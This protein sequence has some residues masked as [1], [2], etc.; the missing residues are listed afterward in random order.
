MPV[1][2]IKTID[3]NQKKIN[4]NND[5]VVNN[6]NAHNDAV[7]GLSLYNDNYLFSV[8]HDT[9]I[10]MWDTRKMNDAVISTVSSQKKWDE[11]MLDCY[12]IE[13]S[14]ILAVACA[15]CSVKLYKLS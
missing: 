2:T 10:K 8:S 1:N 15:D 4:N 11:A 5:F 6:L 13:S 3:L 14:M 12:L 7:T 9:T